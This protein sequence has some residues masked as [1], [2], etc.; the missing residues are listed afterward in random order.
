[1]DPINGAIRAMCSLPD[2]DPNKYNEVKSA[3]AFNNSSIFTP[4]EPGSIFKT[5]TMSAAV[6]EGLVTPQTTFVD[7]GSR[8]DFCQTPIRN[9]ADKV[10][11]LQ[12]MSG[13][14]ENS[15][16][17]G[18]VFV[19]E[20]LGKD[21]FKK[22]LNDFGFGTRLGLE[23]DSEMS[24][25]ISTLS[26]NKG[27]KID[28]YAATASFGQGITVTPLQMVSTYSVIAN[29]GK[30]MKPYIVDEIRY[31]DGHV[32]KTKPKEI[33]QVIEKKAALLTGGML[34][35]VVE[36]GHAKMAKI[37]G[38][39]IGGKTGTAQIPG[40]GGYTTETN[41]TFVGIAPVDNPKFVMLI[42]FEKPHSPWAENS[43]VPLFGEIS[44]FVLKYYGI[45]PT[46]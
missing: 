35:N 8:A 36:K 31:A 20:K 1:M 17:T 14:L 28:C 37:L 42:K 7:T 12:S 43:T 10:Y 4:Y 27:N 11:G 15:I 40:P 2:F 16:N 29:G 13:V 33:R 25:S 6:N 5:V 39:Y 9:A 18:M 3:G 24:G 44:D 41:H 30:L 45:A 21:K 23:L 34:V 26:A 32:E 46:R 22:Y 38:Y 19:A